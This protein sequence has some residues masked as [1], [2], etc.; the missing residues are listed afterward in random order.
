MERL[1]AAVSVSF[2]LTSSECGTCENAFSPFITVMAN[3]LT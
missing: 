1:F 2:I 3:F